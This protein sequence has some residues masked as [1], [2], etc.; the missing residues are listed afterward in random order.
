M[1]TKKLTALQAD[2]LADDCITFAAQHG[3][4][5]RREDSPVHS[6]RQLRY[7]GGGLTIKVLVS[8]N[9]CGNGG[10]TVTVSERRRVLFAASGNYKVR[11]FKTEC[12]TFERGPW[13]RMI[14]NGGIGQTDR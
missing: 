7:D 11:P 2:A 12:Q 14:R 5:E 9:A 4:T 8:S 6:V 13:I 10:F 1:N 3:R